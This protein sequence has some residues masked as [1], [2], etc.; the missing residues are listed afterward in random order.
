MTSCMC[1]IAVS[2]AAILY[3]WD[4]DVDFLC[5][6]VSVSLFNV[7]ALL[8]FNEYIFP[9]IPLSGCF[10]ISHTRYGKQKFK[11]CLMYKHRPN[12]KGMIYISMW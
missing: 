11:L 9:G 6:N 3:H 12:G 4:D 8:S 1:H 5:F 7:S 2:N 10:Q